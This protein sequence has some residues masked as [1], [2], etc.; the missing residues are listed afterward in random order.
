MVVDDPLRRAKTSSSLEYL[1]VLGLWTFSGQFLPFLPA[2]VRGILI[3]PLLFLLGRRFTSTFLAN[4]I[5]QVVIAVLLIPVFPA[6]LRPDPVAITEILGN[7]GLGLAFIIL[8]L[9]RK[10]SHLVCKDYFLFLVLPL[11]ILGYVS[12]YGISPLPF[13][14]TLSPLDRGPLIS[15]FGGTNVFL[16]FSSALYTLESVF[17]RR[18][19]D[20]ILGFIFLFS[21]G[22][23]AA[24]LPV[25]L[26]VSLPFVIDLVRSILSFLKLSSSRV[27]ASLATLCV[28]AG[29]LALFMLA[30][31][32]GFDIERATGISRNPDAAPQYTA[33]TGRDTLWAYNFS[34]LYR[35]PYVGGGS[36]AV[37]FNRNDG[38][39]YY[40]DDGSTTLEAGTESYF[41]Y[42]LA[43]DGIWGLAY[44][45]AWLIALWWSCARNQRNLQALL[46]FGFI[47]AYMEGFMRIT[48]NPM[49]FI[50]FSLIISTMQPQWLF[51]DYAHL[52]SAKS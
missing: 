52:R 2:A 14:D 50:Y 15:Y 20:I 46:I 7:L 21:S 48:Y 36:A 24:I 45:L 8:I 39:V 25:I 12:R 16:G 38:E 5:V 40:L 32:S 19:T 33:L 51:Q 41:D 26:A 35:F 9:S 37:R 49:T 13:L 34:T 11:C 28:L 18:K 1:L 10:P 43:R 23:I 30:T 31:A 44:P 42:Y 22:K 4:K 27:F 3:V 17:Y 29:A 47:S 6:L